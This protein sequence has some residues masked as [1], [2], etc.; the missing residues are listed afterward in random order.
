M[1]EFGKTVQYTVNIQMLKAFLK[2]TMKYQKQKSGK[3]PIFYSN[4]KDKVPRN[5]LNRRGKDLY[6]EN[7]TTLKKEI[8]EDANKWKHV[9]CSWT[10]KVNIIKMST[11]PKAIDRFNAILIKM[12]MRYFTDIEQTFQKFI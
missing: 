8:K 5:K 12:P 2:P 10:R 3:S 4:K 1:S 6:P 7:Y 9:P 11:L